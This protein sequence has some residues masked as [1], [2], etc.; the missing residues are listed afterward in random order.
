MLIDIAG[1]D[2]VISMLTLRNVANKLLS[3]YFIIEN[4]MLLTLTNTDK[5][6]IIDDKN[7]DKVKKF[8][9]YWKK[10]EKNLYYVAT[11]VRAPNGKST[12]LYLHRFLLQPSPNKDVH[13]VDGNTLNNLEENLS[14][15][16][17]IAHRNWHNRN[18]RFKDVT[19]PL[20]Q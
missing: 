6:A 2:A 15:Q 5:K 12:T 19:K 1:G 16:D 4:I 11:N 7:Y 20:C 17:A 18:R 14:V 10:S 13:H 9:W 8:K 3:S